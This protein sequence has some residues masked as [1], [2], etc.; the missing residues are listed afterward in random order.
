[1]PAHLR[2]LLFCLVAVFYLAA[3]TYKASH[4]S[5]D[6]IPVYSGGRC[7]LYG[8]NPY[9]TAELEQQ[10]LSAH[11][12]AKLVGP[13]HRL[14]AVYPPSTLLAIAPLAFFKFR[15]AAVLLALLGGTGLIVA[16]GLMIWLTWKED[17]WA[18]TL[19]GSFILLLGCGLL[20]MGNPATFACSLAGVSEPLLFLLD[21][22]VPAGAVLLD[23]RVSL[24]NLRLPG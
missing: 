19:L 7:L 2:T 14:T 5:S 21:R 10:Y 20:G 16:T 6:F 9:N 8:C 11:G 3:G 1:M 24:S 12:F 13:G 22:Y 15:I 23:P 4:F 18:P 17:S